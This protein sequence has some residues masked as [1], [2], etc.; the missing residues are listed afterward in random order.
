MRRNEF[1][2]KDQNALEALLAECEYGTLGLIN[3]DEPYCVPVNFVWHG[4]GICFHGALNGCKAEIFKKDIKSSFSVVKPYSLIP[5]YFS[6]S[7]SACP[8]TQL[9]ISA[10]IVGKIETV[11]DASEKCAA[12]M[13]LMQK[14]QPDGRYETITSENKIYTK[15]LTETGVYILM[16]SSFSVKVKMG[17]NLSKERVDRLIT[18]LEKRNS[19]LDTLSISALIQYNKS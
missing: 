9:F 16:P 3:N 1:E 11:T 12:L 17:Q 8:A 6:G 10:H 7:A 18:E 13:A 19:A 5:S 14:L 15:I 2:I 4:D